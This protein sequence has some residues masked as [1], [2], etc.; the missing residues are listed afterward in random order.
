M[1]HHPHVLLVTN[2]YAISACL[3]LNP[4]YCI[5]P[6]IRYGMS[7]AYKKISKYHVYCFAKTTNTKI[8]EQKLKLTLYSHFPK[9]VD[10]F[11]TLSSSTATL[12]PYRLLPPAADA[13]VPVVAFV[14]F[15]QVADL[16]ILH[17]EAV[18]FRVRFSE[19]GRSGTDRVRLTRPLL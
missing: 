18:L 14:N 16:H 12:K 10:P 6:S 7:W 1:V 19:R 2:Y 13:L 8:N 5:Q 17:L 9:I 3:P 4:I 11:M 15:V